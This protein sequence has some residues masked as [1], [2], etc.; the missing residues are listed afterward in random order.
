LRFDD[1]KPSWPGLIPAFT[2]P[3]LRPLLAEELDHRVKPGDDD[4]DTAD[5]SGLHR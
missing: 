5:L 3:T 1:A 4:M 2:C